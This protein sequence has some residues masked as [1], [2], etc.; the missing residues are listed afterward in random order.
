LRA[1]LPWV[2][3]LAAAAEGQ[4][5]IVTGYYQNVPL[6][7][8]ETELFPG[9]FTDFNRLRFTGAP[10]F[11][12]FAVEVAYEQVLTLRENAVPAGSFLGAVP[13][14]AEWLD[15][16]WTLEDSEHVLWQH[17]FDRLNVSWTP[18][19]P[20]QI[21]IGR[22]AVSWATTLFFTPADPFSP[23]DPADPFREFRAGVDAA[24]LHL[25]PGALSEIDLVVR[26]TT[27]AMGDELT[28][29]GRGLTTWRNWE[30][31]GWA[32]TLYGDPSGAFA[33]SGSVGAWAVRGE[34]V[35]RGAGEGVVLRASV[36]VDRRFTVS[37]RD[38][39]VVL[40][41]QRDGLGAADARDYPA[42]LESDPYR[43]GELQ[44][45]GRHEAVLQSSYQVH[46]LWSLSA[47]VLWNVADGSALFSPSFSFSAS[48]E[49]TVSGGLFLGAGADGVEA[50]GA[51]SSE[52]GVVSPTGYFSVS[53]FF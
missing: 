29:L 17:R 28:V 20:V 6:L 21:L 23:F 31:S 50:G 33:G 42:V 40:E 38:L 52:Y 19:P 36:G 30:I 15:L 5:R 26:P 47:L 14:G 46:P 32:G 16:Q 11:G 25:Y 4:P 43:R 13:G 37:Q 3:F 1:A 10:S 27:T 12:S 24:R 35:L 22:Q 7:A 44:V 39:F 45:L 49:S 51:P 8:G 48:D 9:G 2:L 18:A 34:A 41:Y 53:W